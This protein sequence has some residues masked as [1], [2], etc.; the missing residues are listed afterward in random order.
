M[1]KNRQYLTWKED[2]NKTENA[3]LR[4]KEMTRLK[5]FK[6]ITKGGQTTA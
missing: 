3:W 4:A 6:A 5:I 2:E 1:T